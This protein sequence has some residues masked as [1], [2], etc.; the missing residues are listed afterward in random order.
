LQ[1]ANFFHFKVRLDITTSVIHVLET[2]TMRY[3]TLIH[4]LGCLVGILL[5]TTN[6]LQFGQMHV[7]CLVLQVWG[8]V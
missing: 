5:L 4:A 7:S 3:L 2:N 8:W 1:T 6:S